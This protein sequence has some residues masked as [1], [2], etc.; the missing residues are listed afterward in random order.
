MGET[1]VMDVKTKVDHA[2][3]KRVRHEIILASTQ[4]LEVA[5]WTCR[6]DSRYTHKVWSRI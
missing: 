5:H 2:Y 6:T 1:L 3:L 4:W